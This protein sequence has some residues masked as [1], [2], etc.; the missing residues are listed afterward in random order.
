M[1]MAGNVTCYCSAYSFP[2]RIGSGS[3]GCKEGGVLCANC[4]LPTSC[5][6]V[7][8]GIGPHEFWGSHGNHKDMRAVST[9]CK[10]GFVK[11]EAGYPETDHPDME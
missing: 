10:A 7:D 8:F 4:R 3:C 9:C 1:T 6:E 11:N 2:H 5:I